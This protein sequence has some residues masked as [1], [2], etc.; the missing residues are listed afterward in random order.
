M[1][2][3]LP[4]RGSEVLD[5]ATQSFE[6]LR[7]AVSKQMANV[8]LDDIR[9]R[10]YGYAMLVRQNAGRRL[11]PQPPPSRSVP[12]GAAIAVG[13][14]ALGAA[15][16][17]Y[18]KGRRDALRARVGRLGEVA[19]TRYAALDSGVRDRLGQTQMLDEADLERHVRDVI[20]EGDQ[21]VDGLKVTVEGRTVYLRGAVDDATAVDRAAERI[22]GVDGVVAVVN[23]TTSPAAASATK[24]G[25]S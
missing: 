12:I 5:G 15:I 10:G 20:A 16:L 22:H 25:G 6:S 11:R 21:P 3:T 19:R 7:G 4:G 14:A 23:L 8:D 18:D 13:A 9:R 1:W 17:L 24:N 2:S